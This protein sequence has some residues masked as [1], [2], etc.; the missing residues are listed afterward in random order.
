MR[1]IKNSII[2]ILGLLLAACQ[3]QTIPPPTASPS[4][5]PSAIPSE[6]PTLIIAPSQT[7]PSTSVAGP[8]HCTVI[9]PR[10]TPGPTEASI[11]PPVSA[12]DWVSGPPDAKIT[13]TEYS[14]F[15]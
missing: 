4:I 10:P 13:L 5:T 1:K 6:A 2:L 3:N 14:D 12:Q 9:S 11:F 15:M 8:A 7:P